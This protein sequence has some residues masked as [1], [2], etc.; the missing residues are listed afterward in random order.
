MAQHTY[1]FRFGGHSYNV[2]GDRR[3]PPDLIVLPDY[4]VV[5]VTE[6]LETFPAQIGAV[7]EVAAVPAGLAS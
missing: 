6:V 1:T 2:T 7:E 3:N 5:R 4:R